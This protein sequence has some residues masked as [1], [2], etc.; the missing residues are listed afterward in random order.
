LGDVENVVYVRDRLD[1]ALS[2]RRFARIREHGKLQALFRSLEYW[3]SNSNAGCNF[4]GGC[5][6]S[7]Y[8]AA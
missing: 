5:I 4:K 1:A 3:V 7:H 2:V 6:W 8:S